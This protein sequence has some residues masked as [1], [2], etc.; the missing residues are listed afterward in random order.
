MKIEYTEHWASPQTLQMLYAMPTG[1]KTIMTFRIIGCLFVEGCR[2]SKGGYF[3]VKLYP[4]FLYTAGVLD[5][6][7]QYSSKT[8]WQF[9]YVVEKI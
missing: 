3:S 6:I 8:K 1:Q 2:I 4:Q 7:L 9:S 5:P